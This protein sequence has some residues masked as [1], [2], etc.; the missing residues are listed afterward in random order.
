MSNADISPAVSV[1]PVIP[2]GIPV[3]LEGLEPEL[4]LLCHDF[5][6]QV[7]GKTMGETMPIL[8]EFKNK[9]PKDRVFTDE[10]KSIV[11][12]AALKDLTEDERK[13]YKSFFRMLRII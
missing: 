4:A 6:E 2:A 10:E 13:R 7:K 1:V 3:G 9:L 8:A 11:I 5:L 12:E